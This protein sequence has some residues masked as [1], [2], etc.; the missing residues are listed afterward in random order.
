MCRTVCGVQG[1][2]KKT[3]WSLVQSFL[4]VPF[5]THEKAEFLAQMY[6][7]MGKRCIK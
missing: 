7:T 2:P 5:D 6:C 3:M 1:R 4:A